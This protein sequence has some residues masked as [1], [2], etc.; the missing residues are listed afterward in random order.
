M[1]G[2]VNKNL[3]HQEAARLIREGLLAG[4]TPRRIAFECNKDYLSL[5]HH[6]RRMVR[7]G[8]LHVVKGPR[9]YTVGYDSDHVFQSEPT[10][11]GVGPGPAKTLA[12]AR[13]WDRWREVVTST[14]AQST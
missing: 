12:E 8:R 5:C 4:K 6:I 11:Y 7:D 9:V 13:L 14:A 1:G 2:T 3:T 10:I